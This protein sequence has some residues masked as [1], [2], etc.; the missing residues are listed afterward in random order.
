MMDEVRENGGTIH[1]NELERELGIPVVPISASKNEGI[2]ELVEHALHVAKFREH[3][4]RMDFCTPSSDGSG[5]V[6]RCIHAVAHL[7]EDHAAA[8][9]IPLK[10][11]ATK[12]VE[13]DKLI[14]D[15]LKLDGNEK[16]MIEHVLV[17]LEDESGM[18]PMAALADMRFRFIESICEKTVV[19]PKESRERAR[20]RKIDRILTGKYLS[21]IHI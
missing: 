19:K 8:A 15:A 1:V 11:A 10:F 6:H 3:P 2:G 9:K 16:E 21:L 20:S 12:L 5:A 14:E 17:Q 18:E 7:I 13:G 4:G